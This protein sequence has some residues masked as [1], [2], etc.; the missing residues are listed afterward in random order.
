MVLKIYF[1]ENDAE[2]TLVNVTMYPQYN[3]NKKEKN[4]FK[5]G[6]LNSMNS[7]DI[8]IISQ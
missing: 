6:P 7:G 3:N 5:S 4:A 2:R 8:Y 1:Q